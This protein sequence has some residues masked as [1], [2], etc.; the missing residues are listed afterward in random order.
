MNQLEA[1]Q[2]TL[3]LA[4]ERKMPKNIT[5]PLGLEHLEGMFIKAVNENYSEAKL[6]RW[7]GWAQACVV[8]ADIG[9]TL[10]DMKEINMRHAD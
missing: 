6:G 8:A 10:E 1:F 5:S 3:K 2:E 7:L 4:R 9:L